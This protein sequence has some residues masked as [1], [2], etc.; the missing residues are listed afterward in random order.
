MRG[1]RVT[2]FRKLPLGTE[3]GKSAPEFLELPSEG[4][5]TPVFETFTSWFVFAFTLLAPSNPRM[6]EMPFF[7]T[8]RSN[9]PKVFDLRHWEIRVFVILPEISEPTE[10]SA[11]EDDFEDG[12]FCDDDGLIFVS[13]IILLPDVTAVATEGIWV[14]CETDGVVMNA[15]GIVSKLNSKNEKLNLKWLCRLLRYSKIQ[16]RVNATERSAKRYSRTLIAM[17]SPKH[18]KSVD[19][20]ALLD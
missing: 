11:I 20:S 9:M 12:V 10:S 17:M 6:E 19:L 16:M 4:L 8:G 15:T 5:F 18:I 1:N 7:R 2:G 13:W 14:N 3:Y